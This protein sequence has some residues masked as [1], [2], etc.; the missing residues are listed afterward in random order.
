MQGVDWLF[1][2]N[3]LVWLGLGFY[4]TFLAHIQNNLIHR[5]NRLEK[6]NEVSHESFHF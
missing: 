6:D 2:A 1:V 5:L 3:I 4:L